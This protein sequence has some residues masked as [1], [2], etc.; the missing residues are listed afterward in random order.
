M[1]AL[2]SRNRVW[3]LQKSQLLAKGSNKLRGRPKGAVQEPVL[4]WPNALSRP[5]S[6]SKKAI[7]LLGRG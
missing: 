4:Q 3:H 1:P 6:A 5:A 2:K 7:S